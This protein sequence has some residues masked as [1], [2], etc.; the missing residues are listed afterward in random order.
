MGSSL[1]DE[2]YMVSVAGRSLFNRSTGNARCQGYER[3]N[4]SEEKHDSEDR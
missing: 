3:G 4:I 2:C 1:V